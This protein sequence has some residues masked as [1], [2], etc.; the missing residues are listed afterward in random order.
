MV[1]PIYS[2]VHVDIYVSYREKTCLIKLQ[3]QEIKLYYIY[4]I[5]KVM[6]L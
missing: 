6:E 5:I 1:V 2:S 4:K 3:C